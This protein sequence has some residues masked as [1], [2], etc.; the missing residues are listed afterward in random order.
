[1][2]AQYIPWYKIL[3]RVYE[4]MVP[5]RSDEQIMGMVS[6]KNWLMVPITGETSRTQGKN[7]DMGNMFFALYEDEIH[8]GISYQNIQALDNFKNI[9]H[10]FHAPEKSELVR[11]LTELD[12]TFETALFKKIKKYHPLQ[13]PDYEDV[14]TFKTNTLNEKNLEQLIEQSDEIRKE[15]RHIQEKN[16]FPIITPAI[17]LTQV[18]ISADETSFIKALEKLKPIY[19]ILMNIKTHAEIYSTIHEKSNIAKIDETISYSTFFDLIKKVRGS[20]L[21]TEIERRNYDAK[22]RKIK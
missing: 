1:M 4:G 8:I 14:L 5:D 19:R 17:N 15:G 16:D 6:P 22:F 3:I 9:A 21:I 18:W 12:D 11:L 20:N 13:A 10:Y 2:S 7:R